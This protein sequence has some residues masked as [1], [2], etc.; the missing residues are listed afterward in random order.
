MWTALA[1]HPWAYPALETV[2]VVGIA[3]LFGGL[4]VFELRLLGLGR[5]LDLAAIARLVLPLALLGF[6]LCALTGLAMFATQPQE[7]LAN[8]AFRLKL[9]LLMLAGANAAW[10]HAR[11]SLALADRPA[12][13]LGLLSVGIWLAVIICGRFIAYV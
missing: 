6:G 7:L 5:A 4:L 3:M 10:F 8:P 9:L 12:R 11:G 1:S 13:A 2:H